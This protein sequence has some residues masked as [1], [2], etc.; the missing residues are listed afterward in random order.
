[1]HTIHLKINDKVYEKFLR[2]LSKFNKEEI[3]VLSEENQFILMMI[4]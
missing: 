1:M 3:E 4:I 2:L